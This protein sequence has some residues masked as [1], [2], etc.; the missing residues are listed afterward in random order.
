MLC[1]LSFGDEVEACTAS[2]VYILISQPAVRRSADIL[3][4]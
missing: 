4:L 3:Q 1:E 2:R